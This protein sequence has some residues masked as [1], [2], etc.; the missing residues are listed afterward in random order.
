MSMSSPACNLLHRG[1]QPRQ[2][3]DLEILLNGSMFGRSE[4]RGSFL[5][6]FGEFKKKKKS[7]MVSPQHQ[8]S[9]LLIPRLCRQPV[10]VSSTISVSPDFTTLP[11]FKLQF[12]GRDYCLE[13]D[14]NCSVPCLEREGIED[15]R[16]AE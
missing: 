11:L 8:S 2:T 15:R 5:E 13:F 14:L 10:L 12:R 6:V 9:P 4:Q 1:L 3:W 7:I 16:N